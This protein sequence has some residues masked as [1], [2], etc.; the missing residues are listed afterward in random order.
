VLAYGELD[1][2]VISKLILTTNINPLLIIA[3]LLYRILQTEEDRRFDEIRQYFFTFLGFWIFQM[4]WVFTIC[5]PV[6]FTNSPNYTRNIT[7][8]FGTLLDLIGLSCFVFG[9][10]SES[11]SDIQKYKFSKTR[12]SGL[13]IIQAGLWKYSRHPNYFGEILLW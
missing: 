13:E 9:W 3:F 8:E 6:T 7:P 4:I 2:Q 1:Y 5:L 11:V 12:K 10:V